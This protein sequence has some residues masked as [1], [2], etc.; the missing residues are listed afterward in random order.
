[1]GII[2][3]G[4]QIKIYTLGE[5][6]TNCYL[7]F[8]EITK[9]GFIIDPADDA[10]FLSEQILQLGIKPLCMVCTHG[11]FDHLLASYELQ[12][13]FDI[14]L[15]LHQKDL[16]LANQMQSRA[17]HFLGREIIEKPPPKIGS[18]TNTELPW[19]PKII[20]TPGHTPGSLCLYFKDQG[21]AFTGDTLFADGVGDTRHSYSSPEALESSFAILSKL[22]TETLIYPGH[23]QSSILEEILK[24][25]A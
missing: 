9:E 2:K 8:D 16:F 19:Q 25:L 10:N 21:W 5:L 1:M 13:A 23:G 24:L 14:P 3:N 15:L 12:L 20:E 6:Q 18:I 17:K 4:M 7:I 22:P 11:H